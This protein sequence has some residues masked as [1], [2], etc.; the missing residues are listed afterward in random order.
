MPK[1]V[2]QAQLATEEASKPHQ[3]A[4]ALDGV[5]GS[6]AGNRRQIHFGGSALGTVGGSVL[7][8][9]LPIAIDRRAAGT[10]FAVF[11]GCPASSRGEAGCGCDEGPTIG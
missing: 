9:L 8:P 2:V 5:R 7:G 3:A 6:P 11:A 1:P 10:V 4:A